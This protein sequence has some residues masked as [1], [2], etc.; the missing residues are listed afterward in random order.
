VNFWYEDVTPEIR[1]FIGID[2]LMWE[3]DFPHGTGTYP[4][5]REYIAT[6]MKGWSAAQMKQVLVDNAKKLYH[7]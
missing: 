3:S 6:S 4:K 7:L 1:D 2:S 5:S